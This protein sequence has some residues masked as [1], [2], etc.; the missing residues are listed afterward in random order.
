MKIATEPSNLVVL[1]DD[2]EE[3]TAVSAMHVSENVTVYHR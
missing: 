1:D 3:S 2:T